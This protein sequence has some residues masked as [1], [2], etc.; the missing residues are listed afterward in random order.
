MEFSFGGRFVPVRFRC[1]G[2]QSAA[3]R[4]SKVTAH[5]IADWTLVGHRLWS[6]NFK[7]E[8]VWPRFRSTRR[9]ET[10]VAFE[11]I[12][13]RLRARPKSNGIPAFLRPF[14]SAL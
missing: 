12:V 4:H 8:R 7:E 2:G 6:V 11:R 13:L 3:H 1:H 14:N 9:R 10:W 5:P